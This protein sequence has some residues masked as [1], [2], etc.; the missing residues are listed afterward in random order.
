MAFHINASMCK[1]IK[2]KLINHDCLTIFMLLYIM[3]YA[4]FAYLMPVAALFISVC[5]M[6][7]FLPLTFANAFYFHALF[8][9]IDT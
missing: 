6:L 2:V 1:L 3:L 4:M 7:I 9:A 5:I 8:W